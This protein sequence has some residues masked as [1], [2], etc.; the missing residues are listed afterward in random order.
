VVSTRTEDFADYVLVKK[1]GSE[2]LTLPSLQDLMNFFPGVKA[3]ASLMQ[4]P[5]RSLD[6]LSQ[7]TSIKEEHQKI[8]DARVELISHLEP[9]PGVKIGQPG[10]LRF[11]FDNEKNTEDLVTRGALNV[12][13][14][15]LRSTKGSQEVATALVGT[16]SLTEAFKKAANIAHKKL[17][18]IVTQFNKEFGQNYSTEDYEVAAAKA[19]TIF[20]L[21]DSMG[22]GWT[23]VKESELNSSMQSTV[24]AHKSISS[25]SISSNS[26]SVSN[27]EH[28]S[29]TSSPLIGSSSQRSQR[30]Q[31]SQN[32]R[33]SKNSSN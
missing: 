31:S 30:S 12:N 7:S 13:L 8:L 16:G 25:S 20:H 1:D 15:T 19:G 33:T 2:N 22:P 3:A 24:E 14:D 9:K 17:E 21:K 4:V 6:D 27:K 11:N 29:V 10:W 18:L 23:W 26:K 32:S 28:A 5:F